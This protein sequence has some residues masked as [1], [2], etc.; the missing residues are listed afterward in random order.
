MLYI[1]RPL[2]CIVHNIKQSVNFLGIVECLL[3]FYAVS[4]E[5]N[6]TLKQS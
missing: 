4:T 3:I 1:K 5:S 6:N 2:A